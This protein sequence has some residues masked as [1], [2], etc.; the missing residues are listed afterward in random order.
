MTISDEDYFKSL[1]HAESDAILV[2]M[3]RNAVIASDQDYAAAVAEGLDSPK[4][5]F[6]DAIDPTKTF[7]GEFIGFLRRAALQLLGPDADAVSRTRVF[8]LP[9]R[10]LNGFASQS[11]NGTPFIVL[12]HGVT[13]LLGPC[14]RWFIAF[15]TWHDSEPYCHD[16]PQ[17]AFGDAIIRLARYASTEDIRHLAGVKALDCPSIPKFK[18]DTYMFAIAT[19][20]A[21]LLHEF[22]HL[23]L[24]HLGSALRFRVKLSDGNHLEAMKQSRAQE[25]EADAFAFRVLRDSLQGCAPRDAAFCIG[26]LFKFFELCHRLY[27]SRQPQE[28]WTHPHPVDRWNRIRELAEINKFPLWFGYNL[29]DAF[30]AIYRRAVFRRACV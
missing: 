6:R 3:M 20:I 29:D 9:S 25:F 5:L 26:L 19:E 22:G 30:E 14:T 21:I 24:G 12:N 11:P 23:I 4:E 2:E 28:L 13:M 15:Y 10:N 1:R 27:P 16:H 17:D 8:L 18:I 7:E